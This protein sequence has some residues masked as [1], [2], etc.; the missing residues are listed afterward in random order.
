VVTQSTR[1]AAWRDPFG[2]PRQELADLAGSYVP[3]RVSV[4]MPCF[5]AGPYLAQAIESVL[6]QDHSDIELVVV[7][8]SS[9][10]DS[11]NVA[12]GYGTSLVL[13]ERTSRGGACA[14]RNDGLGLA[15]GEHV[16]FLD[17]DDYL[18]PGVV[19]ALLAHARLGVTVF[20][21]RLELS[22]GELH[23]TPSSRARGWGRMGPLEFMLRKGL[24]PW[25]PLHQR[26][27]VY[28][29]GGFDE[30]V[31]QAQEKD[32]HIRLVLHGVRFEATGVMV[33]VQ[34]VH[35]SASRITNCVWAETD[36]WRHFDLSMHWLTLVRAHT[37]A[38]EYGKYEQIT[39]D[40]IVEAAQRALDSGSPAVANQY[41]AAVASSLQDYRFSLVS[42]LLGGVGTSLGRRVILGDS[43]VQRIAAAAR[44]RARFT[45][46]Q[47]QGMIN[48]RRGSST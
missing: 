40:R 32:F 29:I 42:R 18:L 34:R 33:G 22:C 6:S 27:G 8:D 9:T 5:N 13:V 26:A 11:V 7:D 43:A 46:L 2:R 38:S 14:A 21:E 45:F 35:E 1:G 20:G 31:P 17:S 12:Y 24:P 16:M 30:S 44:S 41:I 37:D 28:E 47:V 15:T 4:I 36:P 23:G 25:A 3:G 10:D 48:G 19:T 39:G